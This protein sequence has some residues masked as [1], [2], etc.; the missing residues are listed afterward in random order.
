MALVD[1]TAA[2]KNQKEDATIMRDD[3]RREQNMIDDDG[4]CTQVDEE[5]SAVRCELQASPGHQRSDDATGSLH[6]L[7]QTKEKSL[8]TMGKRR[9]DERTLLGANPCGT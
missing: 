8:A 5:E 6:H 2:S 1:H 3:N 7:Q 9:S 4:A